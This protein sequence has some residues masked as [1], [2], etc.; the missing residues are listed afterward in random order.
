MIELANTSDEMLN[1]SG[2]GEHPLLYP[3]FSR[4][5]SSVSPLSKTVAFE[6]DILK[7]TFQPD[8]ARSPKH[9]PLSILNQIILCH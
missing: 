8:W 5:A 2:H 6:A 9:H 1:N 3:D 7:S 4:N